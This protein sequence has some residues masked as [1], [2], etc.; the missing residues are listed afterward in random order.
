MLRVVGPTREAVLGARTY[1]SHDI[2][3][4]GIQMQIHRHETE[5]LQLDG[6]VSIL[7]FTIS[8]SAHSL[9]A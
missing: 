5:R 4:Q 9:S 2:L 1:E 6:Y 8:R 7:Y 3:T